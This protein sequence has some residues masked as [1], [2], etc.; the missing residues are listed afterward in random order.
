MGEQKWEVPKTAAWQGFSGR[1]DTQFLRLS[2][3][4]ADIHRRVSVIQRDSAL[5]RSDLD[6]ILDDLTVLKQIIEDG[7]AVDHTRPTE[8]LPHP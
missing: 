2:D 6:A 8:A 5:Y 4:V 1:T 3:L 7:D